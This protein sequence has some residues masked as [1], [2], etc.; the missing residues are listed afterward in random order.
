MSR[1][2]HKSRVWT[3]PPR[4]V[5]PKSPSLDRLTHP[6]T[7]SENIMHI[8]KCPV[9]KTGS[10]TVCPKSRLK[11]SKLGE[12]INGSWVEVGFCRRSLSEVYG[13]RHLNSGDSTGGPPRKI[14]APGG[15][16][17]REGPFRPNLN[18]QPIKKNKWRSAP[19]AKS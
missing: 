2:P 19:A 11:K 15:C 9:T 17:A 16:G 18:I 4:C 13:N 5:R 10:R 3:L 1:Q 7:I 8:Q 14:G 12:Q 6:L